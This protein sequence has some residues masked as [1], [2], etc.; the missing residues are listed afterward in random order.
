MDMT[1][2]I[3]STSESADTAVDL[4]AAEKEQMFVAAAG[5]GVY[6]LRPLVGATRE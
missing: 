3:V 4:S 1:G 2:A 6:A 5:T